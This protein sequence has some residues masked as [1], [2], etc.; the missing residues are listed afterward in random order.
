MPQLRTKRGQD[1]III[2]ILAQA[3]RGCIYY[4]KNFDGLQCGKSGSSGFH[5]GV[6]DHFLF[7]AAP[8]FLQRHFLHQ[9]A[10]TGKQLGE[11]LLL[12]F[13]FGKG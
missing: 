13:V 8:V 11:E 4:T 7:A 5:G 6:L 10:K 9:L 2:D 12:F 1:Q 3:L